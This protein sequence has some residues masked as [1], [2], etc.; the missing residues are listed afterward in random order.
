MLKSES[1]SC[2]EPPRPKGRLRRTVGE[3][4]RTRSD[5]TVPFCGVNCSSAVSIGTSDW[6]V[7][8]RVASN[9]Y[10]LPVGK[11]TVTT[12]GRVVARQ[13][14]GN[15]YDPWIRS[16]QNFPSTALFS[17][18]TSDRESDQPCPKSPS[19]DSRES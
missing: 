14:D 16:A 6:Q 5:P 13:Y 3:V 17:R 12:S 15:A 19:R 4:S 7:V 1:R 8:E 18:R 11:V 10:T 9:R 2:T